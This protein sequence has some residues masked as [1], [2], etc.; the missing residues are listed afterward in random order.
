MMKKIVL[1]FALALC[2]VHIFSQTLFTYGT[3]EVGKD[4]FLRAYNKNKTPVADKEKSLREYLGLYSK[5]KLKVKAAKELKV[6]TLQQLKYDLQNFRTQVEEGYMVDEKGMNALVDE[7]IQRSHKDIHLLHFYI[8]VNLTM[9]PADTLKAYKAMNEVWEELN[10]GNSNYKQLADE[11]GKKIMPVVNAKDLGYITA[12]SLPYEIE[13]LVYSLKPGGISKIYRTKSALH[14]F[15]NANERKSAGKW[16]IAQILFALPPDVSADKKIE[17]KKIADSVYKLLK[18]GASFGEMAKKYSDDKLTYQGGGEM[19]EFG[20]GKYDLAFENA[21]FALKNDSDISTPIATGYG[22]HIVKRLQQRPIPADNSDENFVLT[23]KQQ[24]AQDTRVNKVKENFAKEVMQKTGYKKNAAVKDEQLFRY[25]DSVVANKTVGN[26]PINK[27]IIFSFLTSKVKGRDWLN[28][29]KDYKL[30]ADVYK[31]ESNKEL[32]DK[33]INVTAMEYYRKHLE[34]YNADFKYQMQEF[35]EGNMLFEIMEKNVWGKAAGDSAGL[36]K[37]YDAHQANYRWAE[38][39]DVLLFNC[40]N[41]QSAEEAVADLKNGKDWK[42]IAEDSEGR[43]Q[44]DS[45]RYETAQLPLQENTSIIEGGITTPFV[46]IGD[47]TASFIKVLKKYP[48]NQQRS[49]DEARGL[50]IN[51]YQIHLEEKWVEELKKK[52]PIK[53]NEA[54]FQSLLK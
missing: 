11:T 48:A 23:L 38:S 6:D 47:N 43:I 19:P 14:I 7:A 12:L 21:V 29:V 53:I 46:N 41:A 13:N 31:N 25:A 8:P 17:V 49:F 22:Y 44:S 18:A 35:K 1:L 15:K 36:K 10:K 5:F 30:N 33:Y 52:Y 42:K 51:E 4:E 9:A 39:A 34:G 32:L 28:F 27:I 54:V 24:I 45:A 2:T 37:Y 3:N 20:T 26:Y 50:V 40:N 16:K